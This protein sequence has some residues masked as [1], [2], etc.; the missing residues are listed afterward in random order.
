M[1]ATALD[2]RAR[3]AALRLLNKYGKAMIYRARG[4]PTYNPSTSKATT[5]PTDYPIKSYLATPNHRDLE[6]G[7]QVDEEVALIAGAALPV[8]P[9]PLDQLIFNS[10]TYSVRPVTAIWSGEQVALWYVAVKRKA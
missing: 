10:K 7:V 6:L 5:A 4:T 8:E 2:V 1:T 9:T 3:A